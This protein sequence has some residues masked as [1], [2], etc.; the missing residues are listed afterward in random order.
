MDKNVQTFGLIDIDIIIISSY[1]VN[2]YNLAIRNIRMNMLMKKK[3]HIG[4]Q[5]IISQV[6][7]SI[8]PL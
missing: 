2:K 5:I 6:L 8:Y 1:D 7:L 4:F 3:Q